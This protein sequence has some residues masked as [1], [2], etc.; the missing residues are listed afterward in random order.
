VELL[1]AIAIVGVLAA[2]LLSAL[3]RAKGKAKQAYCVNNVRQLGNA[4]EQ[5]ETD[6]KVFPPAFV[7]LDERGLHP[8]YHINWCYALNYGE[9][10]RA[11]APPINGHF[12]LKETPGPD[13]WV[14]T[15]DGPRPL[16]NFWG[17]VWACPS[18]APPPNLPEN[19]VMRSYGYNTQGLGTGL[20]GLGGTTRTRA[21]N[22]TAPAV[23]STDVAN[24]SGMIAI[25]DSF[26]GNDGIVDEGD[27]LHRGNNHF[28]T[29]ANSTQHAAAR[30]GGK[31]TIVYCDGHVESLRF[32]LL[33]E[34]T[35]DAA[36]AWWNRDNQPHRENLT[37]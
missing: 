11:S 32:Q 33:Y 17:G 8:E 18:A 30:H 23:R 36:L 26:E 37:P 5:F 13:E 4:L 24:P 15:P 19:L 3:S 21:G 22:A 27:G 28:K 31:A 20:L 34:D 7:P 6:Y 35:N 14:G 10:S 12:S 1:V 29:Y 16:T 25:G 9:L 2:L